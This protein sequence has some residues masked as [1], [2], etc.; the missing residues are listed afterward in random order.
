MLQNVESI[1]MTLHAGSSWSQ[2]III[3]SSKMMYKL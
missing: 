1:A 3:L 2:R